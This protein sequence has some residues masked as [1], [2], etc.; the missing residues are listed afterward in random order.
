LEKWAAS[1]NGFEEFYVVAAPIAMRHPEFRG[2]VAHQLGNMAFVYEKLDRKA[3]IILANDA[4]TAFDHAPNRAFDS[5]LDSLPQELEPAA[6]FYHVLSQKP[7][8]HS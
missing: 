4:R 2:Y 3:D 7:G 6:M 5:P 1:A 8:T